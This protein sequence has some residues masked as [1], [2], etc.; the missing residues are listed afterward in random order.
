MPPRDEYLQVS[1]KTTVILTPELQT[2]RRRAQRR[3]RL[4]AGLLLASG[5]IGVFMVAWFLCWLV[6]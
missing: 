2:E 4:C 1:A 5:V 3:Q 6:R